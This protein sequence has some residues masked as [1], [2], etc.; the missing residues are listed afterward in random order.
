MSNN[1]PHQKGIIMNTS[2]NTNTPMPSKKLYILLIS[3]AVV[4]VTASLEVM[5]RVKDLSLFNQFLLDNNIT[6][7]P[8]LYLSHYISVCLSVFFTKIIIPVSFGIYTYFAYI[9]IRINQLYVFMWTVLNLGG[10]AY[11]AIEWQ[12]DS[13]FFYVTILG[14]AVMLLTLLSL[15]DQIQEYKSK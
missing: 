12:L 13:V 7:D 11:T 10:L 9:K 15:I 14:Y 4:I 1:V 6:G 5:F 2:I 3:C 8:S